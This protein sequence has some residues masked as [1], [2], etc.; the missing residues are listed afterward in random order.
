VS[1]FLLSSTLGEI[2]FQTQV[3]F[4]L[5][6]LIVFLPAVGALV[7]ALL[8]GHWGDRP[9]RFSAL[10]VTLATFFL[11][12]LL[13]TFFQNGTS[14]MQFV[15]RAPWIPPLGASYHLGIDGISLWL[16]CLTTFL[17]VL[18]VLFSWTGIALHFKQYLICLLALET[19]ILGVFAAVDILLFF[20][21]W[22]IMLIPM[23]LLIKIW[24]GANR[25][26][27][28]LKFVLY[29]LLGSVV[30]LI[31]F[32][33]LY[34]NHHDSLAARALLDAASKTPEAY[35]S[36]DYLDWLATPL[37]VEKQMGVFALLFFG[38]AFK[39]PMFPFHTWLPD[40]HV[41]APT[42]GSVILAGVLLKMGTYGFLRFSLPLLPDASRAF[43]PLMLGL[44]VIGIL[45]GALLSLA[46]DDMKKLVAYSSISHLG[47]V[48]L[49]IFAFNPA[50]IQGGIIQMLNHGISTAGLFFV[51]GF[52]YERRH[53]RAISEYGGLSRPL[54]WLAAFYFLISLSSMAFPGTNGFVGE[55][56]ILSGAAKNDWRYAVPALLGVLLG[57]AY[58]LWL[59]KRV[60]MGP[61]SNRANEKLPDLN[62]REI[63]ICTAL[64]V[65]ILWVGLYPGP[66]LRATDGSVAFISGRLRTGETQTVQPSTGPP[67]LLPTT[68]PVHLSGID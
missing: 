60:M 18:I 33:I 41:E 32:V 10:G 26:Y 24:G 44:A 36:F 35:A 66:F 54:P 25:D 21:F 15:E 27:A 29:T 46:Q 34:L 45:Y 16:V 63:G 48:L 8:G 40:A 5:L 2:H 7:I 30:M 67:S 38:F 3:G 62:L 58:L 68:Q 23:Y 28:A 42:A 17:S 64:S 12:L 51:V 13:P 4:P 49:G 1:D 14:D 9:L 65:I 37:S 19:T 52:L 50:G 22:E 47:F 11:S 57:A 61:V 55:F 56:F 39:V 6:S 53:T 43:M 20:L 31:G 59:F